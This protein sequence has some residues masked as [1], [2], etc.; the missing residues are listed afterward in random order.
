MLD[1]L[2]PVEYKPGEGVG[3]P[4]HPHRG[5]ETV[6]Y[7]VEG[8][9]QHKDSVGNT[10]QLKEGWVQW[11]TAGSGIATV[12]NSTYLL[13][14]WKVG[15]V[16]GLMVGFSTTKVKSIKYISKY[17][18][19]LNNHIPSKLIHQVF[20]RL[21]LSIPPNIMTTKYNN[22]QLFQLCGICGN[23]WL[24]QNRSIYYQT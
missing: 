7:I 18:I 2:G 16:G 20:K 15:V 3:A 10:G 4:D 11:M 21:F 24:E 13:H 5:F 6:T 9:M 1:H 23:L 8:S 19:T 12:L 14:T 17:L 22:H